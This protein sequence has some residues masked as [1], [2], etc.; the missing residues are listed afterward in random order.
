MPLIGRNLLMPYQCLVRAR[1]DYQQA[2]EPHQGGGLFSYNLD[3]H[4]TNINLTKQM[5]RSAL[6]SS[7]PGKCKRDVLL[8][9]VPR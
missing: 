9:E 7:L 1:F 6:Y 8:V 4:P 5:V 2:I 3:Y